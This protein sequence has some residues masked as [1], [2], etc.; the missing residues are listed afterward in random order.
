ME[1]RKTR[2]IKKRVMLKIDD[3][4]AILVDISRTGIRYSTATPPKSRQV[5]I[6]LHCDEQTFN[7]KGTIRWAKRKVA[8][9]KLYDVGVSLDE[10]SEEYSRFIDEQKA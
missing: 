4:S 3:K 5:D 9:Q 10:T 7:L 2:R 6:L 8:L 1:K